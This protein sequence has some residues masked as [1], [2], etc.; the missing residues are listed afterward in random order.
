MV[1]LV[2]TVVFVYYYRVN[3]KEKKELNKIIFDQQNQR[4]QDSKDITK[5]VTAALQDNSQSF[6]ILSAKIESGKGN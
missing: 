4:L 6:K 2:L 1:V 5:E 3:E